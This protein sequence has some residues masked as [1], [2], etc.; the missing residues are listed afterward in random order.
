MPVGLTDLGHAWTFLGV[1]IAFAAISIALVQILNELTPLRST[2]HGLWLRLWIHERTVDYQAM[3]DRLA[4]AGAQAAADAPAAAS[5]WQPSELP[6][7]KADEWEPDA[8]DML[9]A[10]ATGGH[11]LALLGLPTNQL[12]GQINAA[13]QIVME[14]P[15]SYYPLLTVLTQPTLPTVRP[16]TWGTR[17]AEL[18]AEPHL[19]DLDTICRVAKSGTGKSEPDYLEARTRIGHAIQRNLDGMQIILSNRSQQS[20][21]ALSLAI[22]LGLALFLP[23]TNWWN[24]AIVGAAGG[25]FA[26]VIG[27]AVA[28]LRKLGQR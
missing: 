22:S 27:D 4:T 18:P 13:A 19:K 11:S 20:T 17:K 9:V 28:T 15:I 1:V 10:A 23:T 21:L 26:P 12:V 6:E 3:V 8:F 16:F 2:L 24:I 25:Y 14:N 5:P 7:F